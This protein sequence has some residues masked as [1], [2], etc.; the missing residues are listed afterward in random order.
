MLS[1]IVP[2]ST[3]ITVSD[4]V[5]NG[6]MATGEQDG[7][8]LLFDSLTKLMMADPVVK[9]SAQLGYPISLIPVTGGVLLFCLI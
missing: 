5:E 9:A 7:A 3:P 4:G 2:R 1:G 6:R 8:F